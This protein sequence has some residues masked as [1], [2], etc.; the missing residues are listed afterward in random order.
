MLCFVVEIAFLE[1]TNSIFVTPK[2]FYI[3]VWNWLSKTFDA[4]DPIKIK[5]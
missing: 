2:P 1:C 4:K 3:T 5:R